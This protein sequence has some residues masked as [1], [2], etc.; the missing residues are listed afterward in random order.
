MDM[1]KMS[2]GQ[3][4]AGVG[5]VV[6]LISLF[7]DW[8]SGISL[9]VGATTVGTGGANAFDVFSGMDIIMLIVA[10]LAIVWAVSGAVGM[11]LPASTG[12]VV[13]LLG[14]V[15]V[16]WALGWDLENSNAGIGAWLG[17][18]AAVA[19]AWGAFAASTRPAVTSSAPARES[20]PTPPPTTPAV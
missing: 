8:V 17:L 3:M 7:L 15:I 10:V 12:W 2:Q 20:T 9:Q 6:L 1:S 5:G 18:V 16:G 14:V 13:A 11:A 19:I 4:I